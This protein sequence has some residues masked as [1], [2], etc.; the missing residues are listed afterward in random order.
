M[1]IPYLIEELSVEG[2]RVIVRPSPSFGAAYTKAPFYAEYAP[3]V[4]LDTLDEEILCMPFL[5]NVLPVI[6]RSGQRYRVRSLDRGLAAALS[7]VRDAFRRIHPTLSWDGELVADRLHGAQATEASGTERVGLL[8]SGGADSVYSS[9]IH[10]DTPQLLLT[11]LSLLGGYPEENPAA[12]GKAEE[13]FR[14]F[15][16][17]FGHEN[18]FVS[19]NLFGYVPASRLLPLWP[20]PWR[21][22]IEVQ[23]GLGFAGLAAPVLADRG[24]RHL[25][26]AA[27]ELDHYGLPSGSHPE[28]VNAIRWTGTR[29]IVDG[30][31]AKRQ[32]KI[33]TFHVLVSGHSSP[34]PSLRPCLRPSRGFHN[35]G[36][37]S[38]CLQTILG[39]FAEGADPAMYGFEAPAAEA[40]AT[41]RRLCRAR[42]LPMPDL[43]ELRQWQDIQTALRSRAQEVSETDPGFQWLDTFDF[44]RYYARWH[45]PLLGGARWVRRRIGVWLKDH[46]SVERR[47]RALQKA[48]RRPD[49]R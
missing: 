42:K 28:I 45:G 31:D 7:E 40:C 39:L 36:V 20:R 30:V 19:S 4:R 27:C 33:R 43:G 29:V 44:D 15:G 32:E 49:R 24:I 34:A 1:S 11:I 16:R 12:R 8:F 23:H 41:L 21:W 5:L 13:H 47:V 22:L 14:S 6:W 17:R 25:L 37:C 48:L 2:H 46:P 38:K 35:C 26:V 9:V 3:P 10:R 18:A